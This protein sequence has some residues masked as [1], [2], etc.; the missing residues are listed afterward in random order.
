[1]P[2]KRKPTRIVGKGD[3]AVELPTPPKYATHAC[4]T[5]FNQTYEN[6]T[7]KKATQPINDFGCFKGVSG[8]FSYLRMDNKRKIKE[9]YEGTWYWDG[10]QVE[11]IEDLR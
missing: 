3:W 7:P 6:G 11:G 10:E 1:M 2:F 4:L 5:C 9:E 8:D